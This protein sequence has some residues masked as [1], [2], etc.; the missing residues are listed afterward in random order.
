MD[1]GII[2]QLLAEGQHHLG[3]VYRVRE[4]K[5]PVICGGG[6]VSKC[7]LYILSLNFMI[8]LSMWQSRKMKFRE[9]TRVRLIQPSTLALQEVALNRN[10]GGN[11]LCCGTYGP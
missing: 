1:S 7:S 2:G 4:E 10:K 11:G 8:A 5:R 9:Y 6:G 3:R